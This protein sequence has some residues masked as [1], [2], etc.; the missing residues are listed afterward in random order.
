MDYLK[1]VLHIVIAFIVW[2]DDMWEVV[3]WLG[4]NHRLSQLCAIMS[5]P[6]HRGQTDCQRE[7]DGVKGEGEEDVQMSIYK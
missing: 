1:I 7:G 2:L 6:T 3:S 5:F 4:S